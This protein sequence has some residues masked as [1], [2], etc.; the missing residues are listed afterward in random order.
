M[1][2]TPNLVLLWSSRDP[3]VFQQL[4]AMYARN[5]LR[6]GWWQRVRLVIWGPSAQVAAEDAPVQALLD[7][8]Q[9]DGVELLACQRCAE[10]YG[11]SATLADLGIDVQ[12]MGQPLTDMLQSGWHCLTF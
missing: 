3:E 5:S 10:N 8:L 12:Y 2:N 1:P 9:S 7:E 4:V 6:N 11:V